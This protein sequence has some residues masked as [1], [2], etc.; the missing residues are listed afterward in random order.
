MTVLYVDMFTDE[1]I[2]SRR[3]REYG[4]VISC[5][6]GTHGPEPETISGARLYKMRV[7]KNIPTVLR[8][9]GCDAR[10]FYYGQT[11]TCAR[12]FGVS[13]PTSLYVLWGEGAQLSAVS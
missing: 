2:V 12:H 5:K 4:Y 10:V 9:G 6:F 7:K 13:Q 11:R 3:L 1:R 8:I